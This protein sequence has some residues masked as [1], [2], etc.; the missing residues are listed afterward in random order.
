M[1][2]GVQLF[3]DGNTHIIKGVVCE[4]MTVD[5]FTMDLV[6]SGEWRFT[7][8]KPVEPEPDETDESDEPEVVLVE[9][10]KESFQK[11]PHHKR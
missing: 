6:E 5:S 1:I 3:R 9:T 2:M 7:P 4:M 11:R 10:K 8:K